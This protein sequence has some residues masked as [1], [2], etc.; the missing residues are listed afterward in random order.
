MRSEKIINFIIF[1]IA[2]WVIIF[3]P[4]KI[5]ATEIY[6][7]ANSDIPGGSKGYLIK[8][9]E[10]ELSKIN[11]DE[12]N[13][14]LIIT[15]IDTSYNVKN[16]KKID[17]ELS[18]I[19]NIFS[20]STYN[21]IVF[22]D[23]NTEELDS[24]EVI[25]VVK[26]SKTWERL[27]A[28]SYYGINTAQPFRGGTCDITE[29]NGYLIINT[30]HLMYVSSDGYNHQ[31]NMF[32]QIKISNMTNINSRTGV[33]NFGTGYVSHSFDQYIRNDGTYVYTVDHGDAYPRGIAVAKYQLNSSNKY[34]KLTGGCVYT[35]AGDTGNNY[36]GY[37]ISDQELSANNILIT[38]T[39]IDMSLG[40]VSTNKKQNLYLLVVPK[41]NITEENSNL[42]WFTDFAESD[43]TQISNIHLTKVNDNKFLLM[44]QETSDTKFGD[45]KMVIIDGSGKKLTDIITVGG[46]LSNNIKPVVFNNKIVWTFSTNSIDT[47]VFYLDISTTTKFNNY[48]DLNLIS[49]NYFP[50]FTTSFY[51][52]NSELRIKKYDDSSENITVPYSNLPYI[53]TVLESNV[54]SNCTKVKKVI[55]SEG[56]K[57]LESSCF[58]SCESL[59]SVTI[60]A[61]C[62]IIEGSCFSSCK[63]LKEV[64]F[65]GNNIKE[66]GDMAFASI[67]SAKIELPD[68]IET[69]G[70]WGFSNSQITSLK[71]PK[72]LKT[73]K[74][75]A[76]SGCKQMKSLSLPTNLETIKENAF[77]GFSSV[78]GELVIPKSVKEI[79]N[80]AFGYSYGYTKI[81]FENPNVTIGK[82]AFDLKTNMLVGESI[83]LLDG[84]NFSNVVADDTTCVQVSKDGSIKALKEG[85]VIIKY[86]KDS[87]ADE[88][89]RITVTITKPDPK[90]ATNI[91]MDNK[92]FKL[93]I[94]Q[95]LNVVAYVE[96]STA[97]ATT[98]ITYKSSDTSVATVD[99]KGFV[100][101]KKAG[102][103]TI[104]AITNNGKS[105]S[106]TVTVLGDT[107]IVS[108]LN[109]DK[110]TITLKENSTSKITATVYPYY[111]TNKT[112]KWSS[113]DSSIAKVDSNGN[114]T[115]IK[116]GKTTI[117]AASG[118][119]YKTCEVTVDLPFTDV[120]NSDWFHSAVEYTYG[121][122]IILGYSNTT[123]FGPNDKFT[124]A[125]LV[126]ILHRMENSPSNDGKSK[127]SDVPSNMWYSQ[128]IKWAVN[129][130][131]VHGYGT[132]NKFA[133]NKNITRE[134]LVV[135]LNNYANYKKK[136]I[137]VKT[138]LSKFKDY[139]QIS[140]FANP[141][142]QWAVNKGV[143][144][145]YGDAYLKPLGTATRAEAASMIF[146]YCEKVGR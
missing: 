138:D 59:E 97:V 88:C 24:K 18:L 43:T 47:V 71:L 23:S 117:K 123:K 105:V 132:T 57:V 44:W 20:G 127:F 118:N 15:S 115:G 76:F 90:I 8:N 122:K 85:Y 102:S 144:T 95:Y 61:S 30:C 119:C 120:K 10:T 111:A 124:R 99:N 145:G 68:D 2:F 146:K 53:T 84:L 77:Y 19:G 37:D 104:T 94:N 51:N 89:A 108:A 98:T 50:H 139:K 96:P 11:I 83:K 5:N 6:F 141:A 1:C 25:R 125:M 73:I 82:R 91:N 74:R 41:D 52:Y 135:I 14:K 66:I 9:S 80:S 32:F 7:K 142:M 133:P 101:G 110:E 128:A 17:Y 4:N 126:T 67:G 93:Y 36:T 92:N 3:I 113:A 70:E 16:T 46:K 112:V 48:K 42:I 116:P 106:T 39:S 134:E 26:Y 12:E 100:T 35:A 49:S 121:N 60:P 29:L 103:A 86:Y 65:K 63:N 130:E 78:S 40:L 34:T 131:I 87:S 31:A 107:V 143:I 81:K 55:V 114:V 28:C 79:G 45:F 22:G 58:T 56:F 129:N 38:G 136:D 75:Y 33:S 62:T 137:N 27:G 64:I 21:F 13:K 140:G 109:L 72:N 54:F 69:I